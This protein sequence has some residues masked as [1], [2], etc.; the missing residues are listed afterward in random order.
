MP[1]EF[2]LS[3]VTAGKGAKKMRQCTSRTKTQTTILA[4]TSA[5]G[6]AVPSMVILS[7]KSSKSLLSKGVVLDMLYGISKNGWMDQETLYQM[8]PTPFSSACSFQSTNN[9]FT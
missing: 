3:K 2:K 4:C 9:A 1:L 5:A 6:Q 8:V 7:G